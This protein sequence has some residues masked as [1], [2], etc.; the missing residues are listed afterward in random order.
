MKHKSLVFFY[1]VFLCWCSC[2]N[3]SSSETTENAFT[4]TGAIQ[5]QDTGKVYLLKYASDTYVKM[6]SS[7]LRS[8][9]VAK[10]GTFTFKGRVDIPQRYYIQLAGKESRAAFFMG[11][12]DMTFVA[13][14]DSL[15]DFKLD[16]SP[17]QMLFDEYELNHN[18]HREQL[19][20]VSRQVNEAKIIKDEDRVKALEARGDSL[21]KAGLK[22]NQQYIGEH[23]QSPVAAYVLYRD[24]SFSSDYA[25]L[26][27]LYQMLDSS[28]TE[29]PY[30]NMV[31]ERVA[32][33]KS[34]AVGQQVKHFSLP[35]TSGR[36][37]NTRTFAGKYLLIDFWA[38]WC[39]P[40][41][42]ENPNVV[43]SYK[44]YKD[45]GF[46]ILGVSLDSDKGKWFKAIEDD[47]L[48]WPH[49]SD[50]KGWGSIAGK[51]YGV[52]AI[53]HTILVDPEGTII[54]RDL[55]GDKLREK[56]EELFDQKNL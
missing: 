56:L 23:S 48:I 44:D 36:E 50:L 27:S 24:L 8:T 41:R 15:R 38:S 14:A 21:Y 54:A 49:V 47:G 9:A 43:A 34:V 45:K 31:A 7:M 28:V 17:L 20:I 46:E 6:D 1:L 26:D 25:M 11:G 5:G 13:A 42:V 3:T 19:R 33:L 53:P 32:T 29:V 2:T 51:R 55:R 30:A 37:V 10:N 39:K 35:D 52:K 22:Q 18:A 12:G 40:C 4:I 16:G